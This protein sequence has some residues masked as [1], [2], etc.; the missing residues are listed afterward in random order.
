MKLRLRD[1]L[2]KIPI[3]G[4]L[5]KIGLKI[6]IP[7]LVGMTLYDIIEMYVVGIFKGAVTYRAGSIAFSFFMALF[8]FLLFILTLIPFV[9]IEG[10]QDQ[11]IFTIESFLPPKTGEAIHEVIEDIANNRYGGLL[12]FGF[13]ASIILMTNGMEAILFGFRKSYHIS[14]IR[15]NVKSYIVAMGMSLFMSLVLIFSVAVFVYFEIIIADLKSS[16]WVSNDVLF[17][18]IGKPLFFIALIFAAASFLY[19]FGTKNIEDKTFVPGA[20]LTTILAI[21]TFRLFGVYVIKF[22]KYNELY[23]SIGTL[24]IFMLFL[25]LN[26]IILL[27]GFELNASINSLKKQHLTKKNKL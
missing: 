1:K 9:P 24:L 14:E 3:V 2:K 5:V 25:W 16:G 7:G 17:L 6:P 19:K 13:F 11:F 27:L 20:V 26:S 22:S 4:L 12:S 15:S 18:Q 8:P 10:F 23:G 21:I